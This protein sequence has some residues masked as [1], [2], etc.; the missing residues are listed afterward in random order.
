[1]AAENISL[2]PD[3]RDSPEITRAAKALSEGALIVFPTETVYGLAASAAV[4]T[5]IQRLRDIKS[6]DSTRPFTVHLARASDCEAYVPD[7]SPMGRRFMD[8]AW[9]GPL[10]LIFNVEDPTSVPVY[11]RL[12]EPGAASIFAEKSVGLRFPDHP[13]AE[14][15][16]KAAHVPIVATSANISGGSAPV[17]ADRIMDDLGDRVDFVLDAGPTR[18]RKSSTIVA[19]NGD[20]YRL[21]RAGVWDDRTIRRLSTLNILFVCTGNTCRSPIAE[22]QFKQML[23]EKLGCVPEALPDKGIL[24]QSAGSLGYSGSPVSRESVEVCQKRGVDISDHTSQGLTVE[25]IHSADHIYAM[26]T[27]HID[28]IHTLVPTH[29]GKVVLLDSEGDVS[30]PIGGSLDEYERVAEQIHKALEARINEVAV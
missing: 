22:G 12:S 19:C 5:G 7:I 29:R 23:A 3:S 14:S 9:P 15:L 20:G 1:M 30:D 25:L 28:A 13:I 11:Q 17:D 10:T 18:Y 2:N 27:Q 4:D 8:K 21:I 6:G 16:L 26:A 24:V